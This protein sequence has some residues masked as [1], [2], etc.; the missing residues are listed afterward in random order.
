LQACE[1]VIVVDPNKFDRTS[2]SNHAVML[3]IIG[4]LNPWHHPEIGCEFPF[5]FK[6]IDITDHQAAGSLQPLSPTK[7]GRTT[8][9]Q[10]VLLAMKYHSYLM[11]FYSRIEQRRGCQPREWLSACPPYLSSKE[12]GLNSLRICAAFNCRFLG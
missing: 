5:T 1:K 9:V 2:F 7:I 6:V 12:G 4:A 8:M 10:C 3:R 11:D